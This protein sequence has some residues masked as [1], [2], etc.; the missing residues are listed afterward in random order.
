MRCVGCRDGASGRWHVGWFQPTV[1]MAVCRAHR[2]RVSANCAAPG[3]EGRGLGGVIGGT[4][5]PVG[6]GKAEAVALA[7]VGVLPCW[8]PENGAGIV[9]SGVPLWGARIGAVW[10]PAWAR[11]FPA[12]VS[13]AAPPLSTTHKGTREPQPTARRMTRG[14]RW[15]KWTENRQRH[16]A[17]RTKSHRNRPKR[18]GRK[19]GDHAGQAVPVSK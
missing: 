18:S 4:H 11:L 1:C 13:T 7:A 9:C 8:S 16:R 3:G 17:N 6:W 2:V 19:N 14:K 5:P 10:P 15:R 12:P